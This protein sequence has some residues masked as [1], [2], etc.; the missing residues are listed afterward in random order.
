MQKEQTVP[1]EQAFL[2]IARRVR[3]VG[4]PQEVSSWQQAFPDIPFEEIDEALTGKPMQWES[5]PMDDRYLN[6]A[7]RR[8]WGRDRSRVAVRYTL[9]Y[10]G[11]EEN[12]KITDSERQWY[13]L[14]DGALRARGEIDGKSVEGM[15]R[16]ADYAIQEGPFADEML[17]HLSPNLKLRRLN[18]S[19]PKEVVDELI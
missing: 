15:E 8:G 5:R 13:L 16:L 17:D 3:L 7:L 9:S 19:I 14:F 11:Q 12:I 10:F 6:V 2:P 18:I 1:I 4:D